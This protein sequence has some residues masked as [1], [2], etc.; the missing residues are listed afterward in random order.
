MIIF[1][2]QLVALF[3]SDPEIIERGS[4]LVFIITITVFFQITQVVTYGCLRSAGDVKFTAGLS[5]VSVTIIRPILTWL[6]CYPLAM[7]LFGAW[8]SLF[9]DQFGRYFGSRWRYKKGKWL[10]ISI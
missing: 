4:E 1:R 2:S 10:D 3:T 8:I 5:L 7:G 9:L 6:F